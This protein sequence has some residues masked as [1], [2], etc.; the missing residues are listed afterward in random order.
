[1][2]GVKDW[3]IECLKG[4]RV[5]RQEGEG[6]EKNMLRKQVKG[7]KDW[8][9]GCLKKQKAGDHEGE[10][11]KKT[12]LRIIELSSVF[13]IR[14]PSLPRFH[15]GSVKVEEHEVWEVDNNGQ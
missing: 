3:A 8:A 15:L 4:P 11:R 5:G 13:A 2:K 9:A 7:I 1:M 14:E 10:G 6:S 12:T